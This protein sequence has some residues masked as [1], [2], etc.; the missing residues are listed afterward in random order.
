MVVR[1]TEGSD[2]DHAAASSLILI[3]VRGAAA[4]IGTAL[5]LALPTAAAG[6]APPDPGQWSLAATSQIDG[7]FWQGHSSRIDTT[8]K[9]SLLFAGTNDLYVA[10]TAFTRKVNA[11]PWIPS[12]LTSG[13]GFNHIGDPSFDPAEGGR[14]LLGLE[15]YY[16]GLPVANTCGTGAIAVADPKTLA[17]R[18]AVR[19][20][21]SEIRK[22]M[23]VESSPDGKLIW[24]SSGRDLLAFS[25]AD[26]TVGK[27]FTTPTLSFAAVPDLKPVRKL[28]GAVPASGVT[29]ATFWAGRLL[30]AGQTGTSFQIWSVDTTSGT[31]RLEISKVVSGESEGL[32]VVPNRGGLLQWSVMPI[33]VNPLPPTWTQ[34]MMMSFRPT[35]TPKLE[36]TTATATLGRSRTT[37][38]RFQA[39]VSGGPIPYAKVSVSGKTGWTGR[40]GFVTLSLK[41]TRTGTLTATATL[42][43][44][45]SGRATLRVR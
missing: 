37:A 30:L 19:L 20:D 3:G 32:D 36:L 34:A 12:F 43:G 4:A 22:A 13:I 33:G 35:P 27:A 45:S 39:L 23:W 2:R 41:P 16:P 28:V 38:V 11:K 31:S 10:D 7:R 42:A 25:A 18:Y 17:F 40:D 26:V 15:C 24:T 14:L 21:P 29:G 6:A 8:G 5:A 9:V 44:T 1:P